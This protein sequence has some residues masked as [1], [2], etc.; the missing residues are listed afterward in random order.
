MWPDYCLW[1]QNRE[2]AEM[3]AFM[4]SEDNCYNNILIICATSHRRHFKKRITSACNF[5]LS[6]RSYSCFTESIKGTRNKVNSIHLQR[7]SLRDWKQVS[8]NYEQVT[9]KP[10]ETHACSTLCPSSLPLHTVLCVLSEFSLTAL[11]PPSSC[12]ADILSCIFMSLIGVFCAAVGL[13]Y[14]SLIRVEKGLTQKVMN[15]RFRKR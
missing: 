4:L 15:R 12:V 6:N 10:R 1:Q 11:S 2:L 5:P 9:C 14:F 13:L 7:L 3:L 8:W